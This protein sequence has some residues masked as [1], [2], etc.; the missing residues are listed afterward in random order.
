[1]IDG[2]LGIDVSRAAAILFSLALSCTPSLAW[3]NYGHMA[4]AALAWDK[5]SDNPEIQ[6]KIT[7]LLKKNPLYEKW[8]DGVSHDI[9]EKVGFMM[10]A[11]YADIIKSDHQH[12]AD[13]AAGSSGNRPAG[14]P[15]DRRNIG[16]SDNFMHKYWHFIDEPFSPDGITDLPNPENSSR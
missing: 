7:A 10:A 5:L 12:I 2:V 9:R 15:D 6:A 13:G 14:T 3:N 1:M 8:T 11:T 4:V 16:Y